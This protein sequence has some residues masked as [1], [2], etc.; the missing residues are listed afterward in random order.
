MIG[1][2]KGDFVGRRSLTRPD[3]LAPDRPQLVGLLTHG[4]HV[5]LQEG[6]QITAAPNRGPS[7]GH[8]TSCYHSPALGR[9]IAMALIA[10]GRARMRQTVY[11]RL[12]YGS[13]RAV[14]REPVFHDPE[15]ARLHG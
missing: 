2:A 13:T 3:M 7:I 11:I 8:V 9:T 5:R 4:P 1:R 15:G 10:G 6:M 14:V 12:A